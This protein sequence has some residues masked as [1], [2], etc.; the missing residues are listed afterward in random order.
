MGMN[1]PQLGVA[2]VSPSVYGELEV[3]DGKQKDSPGL[4][5]Y[6][7]NRG[8]IAG[9]KTNLPA[10]QDLTFLLPSR[11]ISVLVLLSPGFFRPVPSRQKAVD[12]HCVEE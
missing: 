7:C 8:T 9:V 3:V 10:Q 12:F 5:A 11:A 1:L 2:R 6:P 4:V